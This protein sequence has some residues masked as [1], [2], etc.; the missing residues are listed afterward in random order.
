MGKLGLAMILGWS[1]LAM[2]APPVD[3]YEKIPYAC[4]CVCY[5][6]QPS[7]VR[8]RLPGGGYGYEWSHVGLFN[9]QMPFGTVDVVF[10]HIEGAAACRA[11][12]RGSCSG[13]RGFRGPL[14]A[15]FLSYCRWDYDPYPPT[16]RAP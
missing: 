7:Q 15:G 8:V 11:L 16:S 3:D 6:H 10:R 12:N 1:F 4:R 2:G 9:P 13:N 5:D 14:V